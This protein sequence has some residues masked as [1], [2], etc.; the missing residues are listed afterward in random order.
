VR[1][2]R[3]GLQQAGQRLPAQHLKAGHPV[4]GARLIPAHRGRAIGDEPHP[5]LLG[6]RDVL[7][8]PAQGQV[9]GRGLLCGL[10]VGQSAGGIPQEMTLPGQ[11]LQQVG[12]LAGRRFWCTQCRPPFFIGSSRTQNGTAGR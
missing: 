3:V 11:G 6:Q 4:A 5:L 7:D 10:F 12:T 2:L 1:D 8:Q 9:A